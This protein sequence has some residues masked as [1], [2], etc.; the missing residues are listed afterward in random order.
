MHS[1]PKRKEVAIDVGRCDKKISKK[2]RHVGS[3]EQSG[4]MFLDHV[5]NNHGTLP[6]PDRKDIQKIPAQEK[7]HNRHDYV[8]SRIR[9]EKY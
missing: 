6:V 1:C 9:M 4:Q 5:K 7:T 2:I 8:K 3:M